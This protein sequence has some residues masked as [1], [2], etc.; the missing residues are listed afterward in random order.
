M[1]SLTLVT[2][3]TG[4]VGSHLVPKLENVKSFE[5]DIRDKEAVRKAVEDVDFVYHCA[6]FISHKRKDREQ[7]YDVNVIGTR[8]LL[9]ASLESDVKRI[10]HLSSTSA[11][12]P[13]NDYGLSKRLSELECKNAVDRGLDVVIARPATV[14][15]AGDKNRN[16]VYPFR[17]VANSRLI[18]VPPG[19]KSYVHVDD[20][21]DGLV[22]CMEE[23]ETGES[24]TFSF[25]NLFFM[26]LYKMISEVVNQNATLFRIPRVMKLFS[27]FSRVYSRETI[28]KFFEKEFFSSDERLGWKPKRSIKDAVN[29]MYSYYL[30]IAPINEL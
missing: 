23:G 29:E 6:G 25:E 24:Y 14:Y 1:T 22:L 3:A 8:N 26:D 17:K 20:L 7:L 5:G 4:L 2:G 27:S 28:E 9:D 30:S 11:I 19:G 10:V 21:V 13:R 18:P 12:N 16:S 15:G